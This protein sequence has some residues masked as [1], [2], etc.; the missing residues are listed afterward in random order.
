MASTSRDTTVNKDQA[1]ATTDFVGLASPNLP[2][3]SS[4]YDSV[5]TNSILYTSVGFALLLSSQ[6]GWMV[7]QLNVSTFQ[8]QDDCDARPVAPGTC[9][10]F[11]GH[12]KSSWMWVVNL[13][14]AGCAVGS[15]GC[16]KISDRI[17]RKKAMGVSAILMIIAAA[18]QAS[19]LK[20]TVY[21]LGRF[22]S[23]IASG[24][25]SVIP[26]S[27]INEV[28]PPHL[29]NHLGAIYQ[30]AIG[31]AII[32]VSST[33]FWANT[34]TGWRYI[35]GF[36]IVIAGVF[37]LGAPSLMVESPTWLLDKG[38]REEAEQELARLFGSHNVELAMS[39]LTTHE[40]SESTASKIEEASGAGE[41]ALQQNP[42]KALVSREYRKQTLVAVVL[43]MGQQLSGIN[44]VFI[45]SS[46]MFKDAGLE[47]DRVGSMIAYVVNLLPAF[48][49]AAL[50]TRYGNRGVIIGGQVVMI[51]A[52]IGIMIALTASSPVTSI[53]FI[54]LYVAAYA[55]SLGPLPF[56]MA[57]AMFPNALRASGTSLCLFF[58]WTG[59]LIIGISYPYI[60]D[61]LRDLSFLP[62]LVILVVLSLF[63]YK[64]LPETAGRT[65]DEIQATFR[66]K[67][68]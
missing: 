60:S 63:H 17:G 29:R 61:A 38:R 50:A 52:S 28:S 37:L 25:A 8:D 66:S 55:T 62:F 16:A 65:H 59:Q 35:G 10:M 49:A 18:I 24:F 64:F 43:A 30:I 21:A 58:N 54:A 5:H 12:S 7:T 36:P 45:Y 1:P 34:S 44:V 33:F 40:S 4:A 6:I 15:L 11:P 27:Y 32:L 46:F 68:T 56:L 19:A 3:P 47:D 42:W 39:W 51:L 53:V 23:G 31:L 13:W 14:T 41:S 48:F 67:H 2:T 9:L 57:A 22:L 20:V 26:N